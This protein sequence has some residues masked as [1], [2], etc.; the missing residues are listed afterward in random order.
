VQQGKPPIRRSQGLA[1]R[2]P[3]PEPADELY[4]RSAERV[5]APAA[6]RSHCRASRPR[7]CQVAVHGWLPFQDLAVARCSYAAPSEDRSNSSALASCAKKSRTLTRRGPSPPRRASTA[8]KLQATGHTVWAWRK[9]AACRMRAGRPSASPAEGE[10][11]AGQAAAHLD[12][13]QMLVRTAR[14]G[15]SA[16][17]TVPVRRFCKTCFTRQPASSCECRNHL[18]ASISTIAPWFFMNRLMN[19]RGQSAFVVVRMSP[20]CR[21]PTAP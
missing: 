10:G 4:P 8:L 17:C 1:L 18:T 11:A 14:Q 6:S 20:R 21:C 12:Y 16:R 7:I 19:Q 2:T 15:T 13:E 9:A 3:L 5:M